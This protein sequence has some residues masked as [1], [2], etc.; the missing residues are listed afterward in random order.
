MLAAGLAIDLRWKSKRIRGGID[1][2]RDF[3]GGEFLETGQ[4]GESSLRLELIN[5]LLQGQRCFLL[6]DVDAVG[7]WGVF[8]CHD[9]RCAVVEREKVKRE[10]EH[11]GGVQMKT[12]A[13]VLKDSVHDMVAAHTASGGLLFFAVYLSWLEAC[14]VFRL[15]GA[16]MKH[17]NFLCPLG[18]E[19]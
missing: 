7:W 14:G 12:A 1:G 16:A 10:L 18:M 3:A 8:G 13:N 17:Q 9:A 11:A 4:A 5:Q 15:G 6:R 2:A 19:E